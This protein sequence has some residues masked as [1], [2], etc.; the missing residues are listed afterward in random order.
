MLNIERRNYYAGILS[1]DIF[2]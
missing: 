2:V 1:L